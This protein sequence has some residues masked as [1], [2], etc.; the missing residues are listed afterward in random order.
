MIKY[1]RAVLS[2]PC[3]PYLS[4]KE[5]GHEQSASTSFR[6]VSSFQPLGESV[7]GKSTLY[8]L[9][10]DMEEVAH[11]VVSHKPHPSISKRNFKD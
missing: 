9:H 2:N 6:S 5:S 4:F 11:F 8:Q 1:L 3:S 10:P 7:H